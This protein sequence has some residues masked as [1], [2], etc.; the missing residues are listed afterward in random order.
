MKANT[1][2]FG[3][4][5]T[6]L[7]LTFVPGTQAFPQWMQPRH[8]DSKN[9]P[10][11]YSV[12]EPPPAQYGGYYTYGGSGPQPTI[13][14]GLDPGGSATSKA[15]GE[16]TSSVSGKLLCI[17]PDNESLLFTSLPYCPYL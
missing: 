1:F 3:L 2:N 8:E 4:V 14:S 13:P 11:Q 6:A 17:A 10:R 7:L 15:S 12:Y 5:S 16:E 9:A